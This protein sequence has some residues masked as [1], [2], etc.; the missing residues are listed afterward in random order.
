M[1]VAVFSP[2]RWLRNRHLQTLGAS[3]PDWTTKP[4]TRP[5]HERMV[6][7]LE[8][9][10]SL[11]AQASWNGAHTERRETVLLIHGVGGSAESRYLLR[12]AAAL[13]PT[14]RHVVRLNLRGAGEGVALATSIYHAG[15]TEDVDHVVRCLARD[16][17]VASLLVVG[18]SLGGSLLLKLAGE[19]GEMPPPAV[20]A[21]AT[22]S[23]PTDFETVSDELE[24]VATFPYR[25]FILRSVV[26]Q[27][28]AFA[29]HHPK[30]AAYDTRRLRSATTI[31][32]YDRIVMVPMHGFR[33][34]PHYYDTTRAGP[35]LGAIRVPTLMLHAEDDPIIPGWTV[36]PALR[37]AGPAVEIAWTKHG[38]HVGWLDGASAEAW[39]KTWAMR[40]V[41]RF[42]E[43]AG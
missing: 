16:R 5:A 43:E 7:P 24:R 21:I 27:A 29:R 37:D 8:G 9:G 36:A 14:G 31:R 18:F 26:R 30:R 13:E 11:L 33:D 34:V 1:H 25:R 10:G 4:H 40:R 17:R 19:W 28:L 20:R 35:W 39:V 15:M 2:P 32:E 6:F 38:G 22:L 23:A 12:C 42:F 41:L 3:L